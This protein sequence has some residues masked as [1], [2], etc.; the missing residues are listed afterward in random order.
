MIFCPKKNH[1]ASISCIL[2]LPSNS[3]KQRPPDDGRPSVM[4]SCLPGWDGIRKEWGA[5]SF[6]A[7]GPIGSMHGIFTY[8]N[9][10]ILWE[11]RYICHTWI[12]WDNIEK[13][14]HLVNGWR[15]FKTNATACWV[16]LP[17]K[18]SCPAYMSRYYDII[19]YLHEIVQTTIQWSLNWSPKKTCDFFFR[20]GMNMPNIEAAFL[21]PKLPNFP[22]INVET[23]RH[24]PSHLFQSSSLLGLFAASMDIRKIL[25]A[26]ASWVFFWMRNA[27]KEYETEGYPLVNQHSNQHIA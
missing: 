19:W 10:L 6:N 1:G 3:V 16:H 17:G 26:S 5:S 11:C 21:P 25:S 24:L 20:V 13:L 8:M 2:L 7:M 12:L 27:G 14:E 22:S 15:N 9:G 23:Y 4:V 18:G